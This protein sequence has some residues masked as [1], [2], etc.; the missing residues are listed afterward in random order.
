MNTPQKHSYNKENILLLVCVLIF[1]LS[2]LDFIV[3]YIGS[4]IATRKVETV[5]FIFSLPLL[6]Y[7]LCMLGQNKDAKRKALKG[8]ILTVLCFFII[9]GTGFFL[10]Y[11]SKGLVVFK[12]SDTTKEF[13]K[14][15]M[16]QEKNCYPTF[17]ASFEEIKI[18]T[19]D[20]IL[21]LTGISNAKII[22]YNE[23]GYYPVYKSDE[24]GFRNPEGIWDNERIEVVLVGDSFCLDA[25]HRDN[26]TYT[27]PIRERFS[28]TINLGNGGNGPLTELAVIK[29]Y[30]QGKK[31]GYLF[32]LYYEGND[33]ADLGNELFPKR[34]LT[35]YLEKGYKQNLKE[36]QRLIDQVLKERFETILAEKKQPVITKRKILNGLLYACTPDFVKYKQSINKIVGLFGKVINEARD[37]ISAKEGKMVFVYIPSR[38]R[39]RTPSRQLID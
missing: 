9:E 7:L 10:F 35:K 36:K 19:G 5:F 39:Y 2:D 28:S 18:N 29:E 26:E 8:T 33:L 1:I 34:E 30:L 27:V 12:K 14:N 6:M 4:T 21:P 20:K 37:E 38:G 24:Y 32:W 22:G 3:G 25:I 15:L 23:C 17:P 11:I 13:I 31:I 16:Q